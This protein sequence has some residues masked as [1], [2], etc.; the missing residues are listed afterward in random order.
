[1][2]ED[3]PDPPAISPDRDD[4]V[5]VARERFPQARLVFDK[6]HIAKHLNDAVNAVR[7]AEARRLKT[8]DPKLL[9][10]T[11][12]IWLKNAANLT[13]GQRL[14]LAELE[15]HD[16]LKVLRAYQLKNLSPTCG[17]PVEGVGQE[18]P[19]QVV[20][21]GHPLE[22]GAAAGVRLD[23]ASPRGRDPGLLRPPHRQRRR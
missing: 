18:V 5:D 20:L 4:Y 13:D 22:D 8:S 23:G 17:L 10:G 3:H 14:R 21:V 9:A 7:K 1:M 6:F 11:R 19:R 15:N 16:G 12:Y 2:W